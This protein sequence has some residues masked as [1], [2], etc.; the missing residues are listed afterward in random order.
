MQPVEAV[1]PTLQTHQ[2]QMVALVVIAVVQ[3]HQ[4]AVREQIH[5][6]HHQIQPRILVQAVVDRV[7]LHQ[8]TSSVEMAHL[9][10]LLFVTL[11]LR[12]VDNG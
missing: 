7:G 10:L 12:L 2:E 1:E 5:H 9:E 11:D 8:M 3:R 6:P 4:T